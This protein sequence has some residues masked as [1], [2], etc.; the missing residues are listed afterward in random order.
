MMA[1]PLQYRPS[2][3]LP[4]V[5]L[6]EAPMVLRRFTGRLTGSGRLPGERAMNDEAGLAAGPCITC[7]W[8]MGD[9]EHFTCRRWEKKRQTLGAGCGEYERE[10]GAE[11]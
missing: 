5:A 10:P 4:Q 1:H 6:A 8:A 7:H 3:P 11:G 2:S 9:G